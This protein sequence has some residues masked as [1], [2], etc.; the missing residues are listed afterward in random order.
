[1]NFLALIP[2]LVSF[3]RPQ[4]ACKP[5]TYKCWMGDHYECCPLFDLGAKL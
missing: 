4:I 3:L 5:D 1:M 2:L